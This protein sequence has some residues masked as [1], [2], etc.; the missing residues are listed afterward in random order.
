MK[1]I[2]KVSRINLAYL[3]VFVGGVSS[4][5]CVQADSLTASDLMGGQTLALNNAIV[6][7]PRTH[8]WSAYGS[9]G[10]VVKSGPASGGR[11]Y[12]PDIHRSCHTPVGV[13]HI[14]SMGGASCR[15]TRYP[16][17]HGGA[18]M[19][20]CMFFSKNYALHGSNDV[21][22]YNAS[23]GCIRLRTSDAQWMNHN[24]AHTGT[25]VVVESY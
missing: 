1:N 14:Q 25:T 24:F 7:S 10:Q 17:P 8:H 3:L 21:P 22:N 2:K 4:S 16:K 12:C 5:A 9:H 20:Y 11:G 13:F 19:P 23:H 15:S 6:F 18:P